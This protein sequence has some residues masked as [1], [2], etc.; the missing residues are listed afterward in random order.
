MIS[1]YSDNKPW[2]GQVQSL[3]I[4][5]V[6]DDISKNYSK[7]EQAKKSDTQDKYMVKLMESLMIGLPAKNVNNM[8][9]NIDALITKDESARKKGL[10]LMQFSQYLIDNDGKKD[11]PQK[12]GESRGTK[13]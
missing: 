13:R 2:A 6:F 3:P 8:Y 7:M 1:D 4:Y 12:R 11:G 9:Q 10:R 5:D